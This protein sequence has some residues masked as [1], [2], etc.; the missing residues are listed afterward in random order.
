[1][2]VVKEVLIRLKDEKDSTKEQVSSLGEFLKSRWE[3]ISK[4]GTKDAKKVTKSLKT[5]SAKK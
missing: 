3:V 5:S 1:M 4:E 2:D